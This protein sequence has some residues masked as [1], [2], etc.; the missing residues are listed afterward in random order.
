MR[1]GLVVSCEMILGLVKVVSMFWMAI[2]FIRQKWVRGV[3][4]RTEILLLYYIHNDQW[5]SCCEI[6]IFEY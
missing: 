2:M 5:I 1:M 3:G 6:Y 4:K